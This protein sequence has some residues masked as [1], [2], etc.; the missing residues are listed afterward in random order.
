MAYV[1]TPPQSLDELLQNWGPRIQTAIRAFGFYDADMEDIYQDLITEFWARDYLGS[2]DATRATFAT[3]LY[4]FVNVRLL[5]YNRK[6]RQQYTRN[7]DLDFA[8]FMGECDDCS[9]DLGCVVEALANVPVRGQRNLLRLF[10]DIQRQ[11]SEY[12]R[13]NQSDLAN[14]YGVSPA[15]V[16]LQMNDLRNFL[17][18]SGFVLV[19]DTGDVEWA[20]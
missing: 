3:F 19:S 13:K 16:T 9:S 15:A 6:R 2:F 14:D 4:G 18:D 1:N 12:G 7:V 17:I 5:G 11:V 10:N 20:M 8:E